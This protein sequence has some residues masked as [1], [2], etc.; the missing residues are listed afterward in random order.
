MMEAR[1]S[2]GSHRPATGSPADRRV[3]EGLIPRHGRYKNTKTW[4]LADLISDVT[5]RSSCAD[6]A[7]A[8]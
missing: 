6:T 3:G 8:S 2:N 4:Q 5:L 1:D 7:N